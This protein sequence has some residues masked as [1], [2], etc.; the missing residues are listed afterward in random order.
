MQHVATNT[1]LEAKIHLHEDIQLSQQP[2]LQPYL[3][4]KPRGP[5]GVKGDRGCT[6]PEGD[7]GWTFCGGDLE[8][9]LS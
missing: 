1:K 2:Y 7:R 5:F 8:C 9:K 3:F 6:F 4:F